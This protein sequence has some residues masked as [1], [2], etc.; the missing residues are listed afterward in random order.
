MRGGGVHEMQNAIVAA[1][2]ET[3]VRGAE[4]PAIVRDNPDDV[5]AAQLRLDRSDFAFRNLVKRPTRDALLHRAERSAQGR[6]RREVAIMPPAHCH[7]ARSVRH[8]YT[9]ETSR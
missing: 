4:E 3:D 1:Q 2:R 5:A 9:A 8:T 7:F 6:I